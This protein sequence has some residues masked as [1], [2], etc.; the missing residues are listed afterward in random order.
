ALGLAESGIGRG[1][2][3]RAAARRLPDRESDASGAPQFAAILSRGAAAAAALPVVD[4]TAPPDAVR[5]ERLVPAA[6]L[7]PVDH[8]RRALERAL[9]DEGRALLDYGD[10][11]GH[12]DLRRVLVERLARVGIEAA[13]DALVVT[14]GSTQALALA[15]RA[16]CDPGDAVAVESPTYPGLLA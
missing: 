12:E 10:P 16:F 11:R 9:R 15:I 13:P 6:A 2:F 3:V 7:Y 8:Y 4:Y 1:T 14:G 5:L